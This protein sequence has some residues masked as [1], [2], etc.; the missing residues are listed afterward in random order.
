[1]LTKTLKVG[2]ESYKTI[3]KRQKERASKIKQIQAIVSDYKFGNNLRDE[4]LDEI[5]QLITSQAH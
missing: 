3:T 2:E 1:M 5:L 4:A